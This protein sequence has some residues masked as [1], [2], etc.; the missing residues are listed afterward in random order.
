MN[1][2]LDLVAFLF[3]DYPEKMVFYWSYDDLENIFYLR[4]NALGIEISF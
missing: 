2:D 4:S 1:D 3:H